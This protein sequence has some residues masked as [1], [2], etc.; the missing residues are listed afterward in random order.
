MGDLGI[1]LG[2]G[3]LDLGLAPLLDWTATGSYTGDLA[4]ALLMEEMVG[5]A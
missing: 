5:L 2:L 4:E 1:A 3:L